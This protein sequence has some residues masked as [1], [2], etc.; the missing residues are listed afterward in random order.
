MPTLFMVQLG[1]RPKGRLIEQHD[2]FFGVADQVDEL[3]EDINS[4]WP[5]VKN[6]WH[7]DSYRANDSHKFN[8]DDKEYIGYLSIKNLKKVF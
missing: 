5:E 4:H 7:I 2:M 8:D 1:A 3:I 6:K